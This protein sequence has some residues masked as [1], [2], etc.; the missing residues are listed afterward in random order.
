MRERE[1]ERERE[2]ALKYK[3]VCQLIK[4]S[5]LN[6]KTSKHF[7]FASFH[8]DLRKCKNLQKHAEKEIFLF[9][10]QALRIKISLLM[11]TNVKKKSFQ[12]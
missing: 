6:N 11:K 5:L 2:R 9:A 3:R 1:R 4:L 10:L 8:G 12:C 7:F